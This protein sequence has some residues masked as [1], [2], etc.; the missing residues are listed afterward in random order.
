MNNTCKVD[1]HGARH[2]ELE[3]QY[4]LPAD[5]RNS[6]Y[7]VDLFFFTPASLGLTREH[8]GVQGFLHDLKS[9]TRYGLCMMPLPKLL[10]KSCELSPLTRICRQVQTMAAARAFDVNKAVYEL[11]ILVNLHH[12]GV[13]AQRL[14]FARQLKDGIPGDAL[15][16]YVT[17]YLADS[18][19]FMAGVRGL[20]A[21][22]M[23]PG[24]PDEVRQAL[25][26][27]D[28]AISI[29]AEKELHRMCSLCEKS[30]HLNAA[31]KGMEK[32][33]EDEAAYRRKMGFESVAGINFS[34]QNEAY[35][36]RESNLKKW[37]QSAT[38]IT[39]ETSKT[40][41]R[42]GH[43][44]ASLAAAVAMAFA[45]LAA[46][47]A[48]SLYAM[49]SLPWAI[50]IIVAY[51]LKDRIKEVARNTLTGLVPALVAD[52]VVRLIDPLGNRDVGHSRERIRFCHSQMLPPEVQQMRNLS[53]DTFRS[54][55]PPE[56]VLHFSKHLSLKSHKLLANHPRLSSLMEIIR[57]NLGSWLGEMDDPVDLLFAMQEGHRA[58][59]KANRV[60]HLNLVGRISGFDGAAHTKLFKYRII[61]TR[62]GI[63]RIEPI[64]FQ[65]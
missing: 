12:D 19:D 8:Y 21:V 50:L 57:I 35:V 65:Q 24:I 29:K 44:L 62:K 47:M 34:V 59:V 4:P 2:L 1:R 11:K 32:L 56:L 49:N 26:L 38:Y 60:Y 15:R 45:V 31:V 9:Y 18:K 17:Q 55:L 64:S 33:I 37:S 40:P 6:R 27:A 20:Y 42:I 7:T 5:Q 22:L 25:R 13:A 23:A 48:Q 43:L 39:R 28:E 41:I 61:M 16:D 54:S 58:V 63:K 36:Y 14:L 53:S 46:V 51:M 3:L 52:R 10:D 30:K